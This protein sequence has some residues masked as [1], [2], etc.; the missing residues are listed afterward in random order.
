MF[1]RD[2]L[3]LIW[4]FERIVKEQVEQLVSAP[5]NLVDQVTGEII[6][7][8]RT[9]SA[10]MDAFPMLREEV[11]RIVNEHIREREAS[12]KEH[13]RWQINF[14]LS[15]INTNHED[16]IGFTQA[17][18]SSTA[19]TQSKKQSN[20]VIRRG[21][22]GLQ[23][24]GMMRGGTKE[25]WFVLTAESVAWFKDDEE[26]DKKYMIQLTGDTLKLRTEETHNMF[27]AKF[28]FCIFSTENR[29]V[30]KDHRTLDLT[31]QNAEDLE[32]WKAS[33]LRAGVYPEYQSDDKDQDSSESDHRAHSADPQLERQVETIRNLVDSYMLI[34]MKT[35]KDMTPKMVMALMIND[36][37]TFI[38][39][40]L[41]ANLYQQC[42][43]NML[44]EES[45]SEAERREELLKMYTSLKEALKIIGD[46]NVSTVGSHAPPPVDNS[47]IADTPRNSNQSRPLKTENNYVSKPAP[48]PPGKG[49]AR[50]N[51]PP[52]ARPGP[53]NMNSAQNH[54][55]QAQN[56]M[57]TMNQV[58]S[59]MKQ[60][61]IKPSHVMSAANAM[62]PM[63]PNRPGGAARSAP[64]V[65]KRPPTQKPP[66]I[67]NRPNM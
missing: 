10:H 35:L 26:K 14:E 30:Y 67:P 12:C 43:Q 62:A 51:P 22:L 37:K 53:M 57:N 39:E 45:N 49:A 25:F 63:I 28:A 59:G 65:P 5:L 66:T 18:A 7:A 4:L 17:A 56:T 47:W 31:V 11:D 50:K 13:V 2:S 20:Q 15:Y 6:N 52:P 19:P 3:H 8:V 46:I 40:E 36:T 41:L 44:M 54:M 55:A 1:G 32:S 9:C 42:D 33:F 23:N 27:G 61:G 64:M 24:V 21:W 29:N 16:F 34:V 48:M 60:M 58:N 38:S